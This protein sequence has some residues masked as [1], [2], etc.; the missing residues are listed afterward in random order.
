MDA[1]KNDKEHRT[2]LVQIS[3][4]I[5]HFKDVKSF[6]ASNTTFGSTNCHESCS[7]CRKEF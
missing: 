4:D 5:G 3:W 2:N 1:V 6:I 7:E